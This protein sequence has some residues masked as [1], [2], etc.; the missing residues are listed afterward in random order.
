ML[1]A[2]PDA[3]PTAALRAATDVPA[4]S[5]VHPFV[6][7][8]L[9]ASVSF[10]LAWMAFEARASR[11]SLRGATARRLGAPLLTDEC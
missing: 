3:L 8:A 4:A 11:R 10:G 7:S 9:V 5:G 1:D 6:L 2:L